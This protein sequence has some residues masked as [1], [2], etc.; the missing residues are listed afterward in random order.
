MHGKFAEEYQLRRT[1]L[2]Y[3]QNPG[4]MAV[5][6]NG[7]GEG[8]VRFHNRQRR[9]VVIAILALCIFLLKPR[10]AVSQLPQDNMPDVT[11]GIGLPPAATPEGDAEK[12]NLGNGDLTTF[13]PALILPQR[14][15]SKPLVLGFTYDSSQVSLRLDTY[16][17]TAVGG[18]ESQ[19]GETC[20]AP[21]FCYDPGS[22]P[23]GGSAYHNGNT[24]MGLQDVTG[25]MYYDN[26]TYSET[27]RWNNPFQN[28]YPLSL[29]IPTLRASVEVEGDTWAYTAPTTT[30]AM[31]TTSPQLC[32]TNFVFTD[33]SG[34]S[35]SFGSIYYKTPA[36]SECF[37]ETTDW[38]NPGAAM[39]LPQSEATDYSFYRLDVSNLNDFTVTDK[40][41]TIYHFTQNI[42]GINGSNQ[43]FSNPR[44]ADCCGVGQLSGSSVSDAIFDLP[45]SIVDRNGNAIYISASNNTITD[46]LGRTISFL[47]NPV[48]TQQPQPPAAPFIYNSIGYAYKDSNGNPQTVLLKQ[49]SSQNT[50]TPD[51]GPLQ[52]YVSEYPSTWAA[53]NVLSTQLCW[54]NIQTGGPPP[55]YPQIAPLN[56]GS[57]IVNPT[58]GQTTYSLLYSSTNRAL[59]MQFDGYNHLTKIQYPSGGYT[60]YDYAEQDYQTP[61]SPNQAPVD[62]TWGSARVA[63]KYECRASSGTCSSEDKTT[64][65]WSTLPYSPQVTEADVTDPLGT[66]AEHM[67]NAG[68][69]DQPTLFPELSSYMFDS[70]QAQL[71][72]VVT[73]SFEGIFPSDVTTTIGSGTSAV[74]SRA[75]TQYDSVQISSYGLNLGSLA[76]TQIDNVAQYIDNPTEID[77]YGFDTTLLRKTANTYWYSG[78]IMD[79]LQSSTVT[80]PA[81]GNTATTTYS[82]D[83]VGNAQTKTVSGTNATT[84]TYDYRPLDAWGRPT[85]MKDG[86]SN[87]TKYSYTDSWGDSTCAPSSNLSAYLT[88][89]TNAYSQ[90]TSYA[91]NS[92]T[93]TVSSVTDV[94]SQTTTY[95]YDPLGR[96][97]LASYPDGGSTSNSYTDTAPNSVTTTTLQSNGSGSPVNIVS[98]VVLDGLSRKSQTQLTDSYG[99]DY[100]DTAYDAVDRVASV[101][102]PYRTGDTEYYTQ[103]FYDALDR[104]TKQLEQ[105]GISLLQWCYN[106]VQDVLHPQSNCHTNG[107]SFTP[108][109]WVDSSDEIGVNHQSVMDGLGHMRS[110]VEPGAMETQYTYDAFGNLWSVNQKG[111]STDTARGRS[112]SYTGLSQLIQSYNP[113]TGYICYG[114]TSGGG[115]PNGTNCTQNYDADGNLGSKTDARGVLT[116]YGYDNLNRLVSKVFTSDPQKT[117]SSCYQYGVLGTAATNGISRLLNSW[118]QSGSCS[119]ALPQTG[120][121]TARMIQ[122]YD[123][124]GRLKAEQQCTPGNCTATASSPYSLSYSYDFAGHLI[125]A[126]DGIGQ[127]NW[128]PG[129]DSSGRITGVTASTL[130][131]AQFYPSQLLSVQNYSAAGAMTNWTMGVPS[132]GSAALT[133]TKSYDPQR[134][135]VTSESVT[136]HE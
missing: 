37:T 94:N 102:N 100:V 31:Y 70:S 20:I 10:M 122:T 98:K 90:A 66:L 68:T 91:Y 35:H 44:G 7:K 25:D 43:R 89:V 110:L 23:L 65:Q 87:V 8:Q 26:Y 32:V 107:S 128:S 27:M 133:G 125:Q 111:T 93:G 109:E 99:I 123:Q 97:T 28:S 63:H 19:A 15:G 135:W 120:F 115:S 92:C 74:S 105:D 2:L 136:G 130:W 18:N 84:Q 106:N 21:W 124:M 5:L 46:T 82:M 47:T 14:T 104:K 51:P 88:S 83:G 77:E 55:L 64:Y 108:A 1:D 119:S 4:T 16:N 42:N 72:S 57:V 127:A 3:Q 29:N 6:S 41:G 103:Y 117:F 86:L 11:S 59:Q 101:S 22:P 96:M 39:I 13:I 60:R 50:S 48:P 112:F 129:F 132:T 49:V 34:A 30:D 95:N 53:S 134:L 52:T 79:R 78:Q 40:D 69:Q 80:D 56:F 61:Y 121:Q 36:M 24:L 126:N 131:P 71:K 67:F 118:T 114:T 113:E 38:G 81:S 33:W 73:N 116:T 45:S 54:L 85:Q 75:I 62:C 9:I 58:G 17:Q 12:V 76:L